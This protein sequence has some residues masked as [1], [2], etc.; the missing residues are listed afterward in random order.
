MSDRSSGRVGYYGAF[1]LVRGRF[2]AR[3]ANDSTG[4][5]VGDG[6]S[7]RY[8][9]QERLVAVAEA[10]TDRD[11]LILES[12]QTVK[13]ATGRQLER[14]H[15]D[16]SDADPGSASRHRRRVLNR[17]V[18]LRVLGRLER[19]IGGVRAGSAGFVFGV[20]VVGTRLFVV[21]DGSGSRSRPPFTPGLSFLQHRLAITELY[22]QLAEAQRAG[23]CELIEFEA[24]PDC[25]R[26]FS[27]RGGGRVLLKPDAYARAG[28]G[29]YEYLWLI[30]VDRAAESRPTLKAK[31]QRYI[32]YWL[33]GREDTRSSVFPAVLWLVP[34][35]RRAD[36][37]AEVIDR[38][39]VDGRRL[40]QVG[41][42]A[43]AVGILS[44]RGYADPAA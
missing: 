20:D 42:F 38:L 41:L 8:A 11:W 30:E 4:R 36:A 35:E 44:G 5:V 26:S 17:L 33:S 16:S 28:S 25:W 14:L 19:R 7:R 40:F 39:P 24:E 12:L 34:D 27:G 23:V 9:S 37:L 18:G 2:V 13:V 29:G 22:V 21:H 31:C 43:N 32:D 6:M 15:F 1:G 10:M 3:I